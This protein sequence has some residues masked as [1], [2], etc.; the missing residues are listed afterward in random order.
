MTSTELP[1]WVT[2]AIVL[3]AVGGTA[4]YFWLVFT[5]WHHAEQWGDFGSAVGPFVGLLNVGA[6]F[7]ALYSVRLQRR[8]LELQRQELRDTRDEMVEQRRQF[9]RTAKAQEELVV[10][11][12]FAASAAAL[13]SL[14]QGVTTMIRFMQD[15]EGPEHSEEDDKR[16][17][18]YARNLEVLSSLI[19]RVYNDAMNPEVPLESPL[20]TDLH[21]YAERLGDEE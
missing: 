9:E 11:Q 8:E 6:L 7:A 2:P 10:S 15:A 21:A 5:R 19:S 1:R 12:R 20:T 4:F 16:A 17:R 3:V 18:M 13:A 14:S